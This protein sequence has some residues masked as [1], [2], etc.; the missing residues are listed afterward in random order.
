MKNEFTSLRSSILTIILVFMA[1][2][3][4][5]VLAQELAC[6]QN[7]TEVIYT[8]GVLTG[9][10]DAK[11][12][13]DAIRE[14]GINYLIDPN[15]K[16]GYTLA[17]NS[18]ESA[19]QD[20]F[21]SAVQLIGQYS[22][23][24]HQYQYYSEIFNGIASVTELIGVATDTEAVT[25]T[26][27]SLIRKEG[28][29]S[30]LAPDVDNAANKYMVY[31]R[32]NKKVLA[33]SH[34]QGGFFVNQ[35][36]QEVQDKMGSDFNPKVF[37][38]VEIAAPTN[39]V[40]PRGTYRTWINDSIRFVPGAMTP[41]I[42]DD[43]PRPASSDK[44]PLADRMGHGFLGIYLAGEGPQYNPIKQQVIEGIHQAALTFASNCSA[45]IDPN[46]NL[47][48]VGSYHL[49]PDQTY[50]GFVADTAHVDATSTISTDSKVCD[51]AL[52]YDYSVVADQSTVSGN[53]AVYHFADVSG[54]TIKDNA[55]IYNTVE[56]RKASVSGDSL[57]QGEEHSP[58]F[59]QAYLR[60]GPKVSGKTHAYLSA[61]SGNVTINGSA[62]GVGTRIIES[63][64]YEDD[65]P[66]RSANISGNVL[67]ALTFVEGNLNLSDN[68]Q[69]IHSHLVGSL[70]VTGNGKMVDSVLANLEHASMTI[71]PNG[72]V[73]VF[74]T[75]HGSWSV[76]GSLTNKDCSD[77]LPEPPPCVDIDYSTLYYW[78]FTAIPPYPMLVAPS[79]P[80]PKPVEPPPPP[81]P[82]SLA[83]L[84][85]AQN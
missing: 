68:A 48:E 64:I 24:D 25:E 10:I 74:H 6:S 15:E 38:A 70:T 11:R 36:Y 2:N 18:N 83:D 82:S 81:A 1:L 34:S 13:V 31:L 9:Q 29:I 5:T 66:G 55:V 22:G 14:I 41:N 28:A 39:Q 49:N 61:L 20:F 69:V 84:K 44:V 45:C 67:L 72:Y 60:S 40:L 43:I 85:M 37:A 63:Q 33:I 27:A 65:F 77:L 8:N 53:A 12:E 21:E 26:L 62:T 56:I 23:S 4:Q 78:D 52:V 46:T 51:N 30:P 35:A 58:I 19:T 59:W 32:A 7:G 57:I 3:F 80:E 73:S 79:L 76:S 71:G 16:V 54:S 50:G 17:Y 47:P 42:L 75:P